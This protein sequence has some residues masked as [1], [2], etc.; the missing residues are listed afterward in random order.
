[1]D[2]YSEKKNQERKRIQKGLNSSPSPPSFDFNKFATAHD[3]KSSGSD[4]PRTSLIEFDQLS[5]ARHRNP[6]TYFY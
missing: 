5:H 3:T 2:S 6:V 1:M 4:V